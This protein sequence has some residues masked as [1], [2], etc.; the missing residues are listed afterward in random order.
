MKP[1][2]EFPRPRAV[3]TAVALV[4]ALAA[5]PPLLAAPPTNSSTPAADEMIL[6]PTG[7]RTVGTSLEERQALAR[8][9]GC[10]PTWLNDDLEKHSVR[11]PAY[12]IDRRPVTNGQY[13]AFVAATG[14]RAP[15]A[16]GS[17]APG[18]ADHP[19]VDVTLFEAEAYA[20][21]SGKR[22][23]TAEEREVAAQGDKPGLFPW[24]DNWPGPAQARP[25]AAIPDWFRPGTEAVGTG[26][27][28]RSAAGMEDFIQLACEWTGTKIP[29]HG[30]TFAA[31]RGTSWLHE[32]AV[33][34][35][36][37]SSY[38]VLG[39][40]STPWIGFRCALDGDR[41]GFERPAVAL[42]SVS[43]DKEMAKV[44]DQDGA[45]TGVEVWRLQE[46]PPAIKSHLL[47]W[48]RSFLGRD[49]QAPIPQ[50][51]GF[52]LHARDCG[53]WPV[54]LFL[55]E[56]LY[57]NKAS[58][59][60]GSKESDPI[61]QPERATAGRSAYSLHFPEIDVT[62]EFVPGDDHVD[63]LTT[64]ANKTD[65]EGEF[66]T[67]SCYSLTNHPLFYD[68]EMVRTYIWTRDAGFVSLRQIPRPGDCIRWIQPSDTAQ[69]GGPGTPAAMAVTS[70]DG[71]WVFASVRF[72]P[73]ATAEVRGNT[74]LN[75]L[76]TEAPLTVAS[77]AMRTT[78]QRLYFLRGDLKRL[79]ELMLQEASLH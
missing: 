43:P 55:S 51:R 64:V 10:D 40:F 13:A 6:V 65:R 21:W 53:P 39:L 24:G 23:P 50:A 11:L 60:Y 26:R 46:A 25:K 77:H 1:L 29:H 27:H 41:S 52:L 44:P 47:A 37:A 76:H 36:T 62:Y 70:R 17:F 32:D 63:L 45:D 33:N 69:Y 19:V 68:G 35:R 75:C 31:V 79:Q 67:T 7:E 34:F 54:D 71:R 5:L 22:L 30:T 2:P 48:T 49:N 59:L 66:S 20:K 58:M 18:T 16:G 78:R 73:G 8:R 4:C 42:P 12:W 72:E 15:W 61:L 9:F 38:W 28:G 56:A 14:A 3:C 74:W 57:W